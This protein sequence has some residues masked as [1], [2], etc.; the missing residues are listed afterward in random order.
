MEEQ[1]VYAFPVNSNKNMCGKETDE[2]FANSSMEDSS[3]LD[4]TKHKVPQNHQK[5]EEIKNKCANYICCFGAVFLYV[6]D[7]LINICSNEWVRN[8]VIVC[9]TVCLEVFVVMVLAASTVL[10]TII[11]NIDDAYKNR[12]KSKDLAD[13]ESTVLELTKEFNEN[14]ENTRSFQDLPVREDSDVDDTFIMDEHISTED[15]NYATKL[16]RNNKLFMV[17]PSES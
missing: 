16:I 17:S 3:I 8:V 6:L 15:D 9:L 2:H 4:S 14:S 12:K 10:T 1:T 13:I 7:L 11:I 5:T